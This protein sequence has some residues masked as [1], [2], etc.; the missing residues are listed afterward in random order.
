MILSVILSEKVQSKFHDVDARLLIRIYEKRLVGL[1]M[2]TL[3]WMG[4]K[5]KAFIRTGWLGKHIS[6]GRELK[7][8]FD[9]VTDWG[10][11]GNGQDCYHQNN[12][13]DGNSHKMQWKLKAIITFKTSPLGWFA[14]LSRVPSNSENL[15]FACYSIKPDNIMLENNQTMQQVGW[16][17]K[18]Q[19]AEYRFSAVPEQKALVSNEPLSLIYRAIDRNWEVELA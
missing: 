19:N 7:L 13:E 18:Y 2:F 9:P 6:P 15:L 4:L 3:Q 14:L 1:W 11:R 10:W 17:E 8:R 12:G 16:K 5:G